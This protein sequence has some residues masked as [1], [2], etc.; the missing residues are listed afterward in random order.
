MPF[1]TMQ[2]QFPVGKVRCV[3]VIPSGEV[4]PTVLG[5]MAQKTVPFHTTL[6]HAAAVGR[7][8]CVHVTPSGEVTAMPFVL[9]TA[10]NTVPFQ[11]MEL[12]FPSMGRACA[13]Q[14]TP[15]EEVAAVT[16][17]AARATVIFSFVQ[18]QDQTPAPTISG[19]EDD[20]HELPSVVDAV[21]F[22]DEPMAMIAVPLEVRARQFAVPGIVCAVQLAPSLDVAASV[23]DPTAMKVPLLFV[24]EAHEEV[25]GNVCEDQVPPSLD[26]AALLVSAA[27]AA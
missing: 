9:E 21:R 23:P 10:Q 18:T 24:T 6:V 25:A 5:D 8:L 16:E 19:K 4:A 3:Q 17:F 22:E 12:Q 26:V 14:F 7:V 27:T 2:R 20:D 15:S 13:V 11:A 1:Q